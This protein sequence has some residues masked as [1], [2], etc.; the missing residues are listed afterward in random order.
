MNSENEQSGF[1]RQFAA[2][3]VTGIALLAIGYYLFPRVDLMETLVGIA[4]MFFGALL[5]LCSPGTGKEEKNIGL[6]FFISAIV[7]LV[8]GYYGYYM[9]PLLGSVVFMA[10]VALTFFGVLWV[11]LG[12]YFIFKNRSSRSYAALVTVIIVSVLVV[13]LYF[14]QYAF[15]QD[16]V[17]A[18]WLESG[19]PSASP[20]ID[21]PGTHPIVLLDASCN[22]HDWAFQLP[23]DWCP[24]SVSDLELVAIVED[25]EEIAIQTC[26]Y[27][28]GPPITRYQ[29]F[30]NVSVY[31]AKTGELVMSENLNGSVPSLCPQT[32]PLSQTTIYGQPLTL[33]SLEDWLADIVNPS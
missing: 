26:H 11:F 22:A 17:S 28:M 29:Y 12:I 3:L 25:Q 4:I 24:E 27:N 18:E 9:A 15:I 8:F 32:A 7:A 33:A 1:W 20:Y 23:S 21:G 13:F 30:M 2:F 31:S 6:K 19:I 5:L 16:A 14:G 10:G